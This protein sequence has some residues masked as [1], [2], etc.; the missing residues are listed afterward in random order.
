MQVDGVVYIKQENGEHNHSSDLLKKRVKEMEQKAVNNAVNNSTVPTRTVL[1]NLSNIAQNESIAA[2]TSMSTPNSLKMKIYRARRKEHGIK[3]KLPSTPDELINLEDKLQKLPSGEQFLVSKAKLDEESVVLIFM[4]EFGKRIL[5]NSQTWLMDGTFK[6]VPTP[7]GQLYTVFG[8]GG[9]S[10]EKIY[11][12]T[13][14]LLPNKQ[15]QTYDHALYEL[16][17]LLNHSPSNIYI[18]FEQ[19]VIKSIQRIFPNCAV[20]GCYFHWKKS[21]FANIGFK[22]C[23]PLFHEN[24][25]FQVGVDLLYTL[26]L[27]PTTDVKKAFDDI[28]A[29]YFED[30][31]QDNEEVDNFVRYFERA[32]IGRQLRA[33]KRSNPL[34]PIDMWNI[35]ERVLNDF[36]TTNNAVESW[37]ARWNNSLGTNH[38]IYCV[39]NGFM[40]EDALARTK[41]QLAVAGRVTDPNPGRCTK[42]SQRMEFMKKSLQNYDSKNL[43]EFLFVNREIM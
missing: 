21:I 5:S 26:S 35:R 11:P 4:S 41:F 42:R 1:S 23:L 20:G 12:C 19:A 16:K 25:A 10:D 43:K 2:A 22:G 32:F 33:G 13:Y 9:G 38:N 28:V 7:F 30:N 31:F 6:T 14:M 15:G 40:N 17:I 36:Q 39:I 18:D 37:N 27:L 29:P 3:D 24:E 8:L 34:F